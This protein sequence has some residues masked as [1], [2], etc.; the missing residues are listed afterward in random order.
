MSE[1]IMAVMKVG[2]IIAFTT[3]L[4]IS[5]TLYYQYRYYYYKE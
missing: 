5:A 1:S 2:Y 4:A 3:F